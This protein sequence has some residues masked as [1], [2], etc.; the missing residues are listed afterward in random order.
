MRSTSH[1]DLLPLLDSLTELSGHQL[2]IIRQLAYKLA[3]YG[4]LESLREY[5]LAKSTYHSTIG[6]ETQ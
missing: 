1:N 3:E 4:D 6:R 2:E 5:E